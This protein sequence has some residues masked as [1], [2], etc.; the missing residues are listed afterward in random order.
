MGFTIGRRGPIHC[1]SSRSRTSRR[2]RSRASRSSRASGSTRPASIVCAAVRVALICPAPPGSRLGNRITA[3]RWQSM[4][5]ELGH[6][7]SIAGSGSGSAGRPDAVIALHARKS[8][9]AVRASR[10]LHPERPVVVALTGTDLY[11][12]IHHDRAAQE[13][14]ELADLLIVL[15]P[16]GAAELPARL[17]SKVRVVPQSAP[18]PRR[19]AAPSPRW[20]E[21]AVVGHLRREKDPLRAAMAARLLPASSRIRVIHAGRALTG[22]LRRAALAEQRQNPRY[23]WLGE[24]PRW[25]ARALIGR[26]RLLALTSEMEGGANVVSEAV[27]AGTPVL[28]SRIPSMEAIFGRAYPGLFPFGSTRALAALLS[29]AEGD[30]AFLAE[31]AARSRAL[32]PALSPSREKAALR[33][34]VAELRRKRSRG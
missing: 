20:F 11:R 30:P 29:R 16:A 22:G 7:A 24:L 17:R 34:V 32:R 14:L 5:R 13:S 25:Q 23:R 31:L 1:A 12:D 4:L 3:L 27:A 9:G 19:K 28:A 26:A 2:V 21:V 8:A 15:H 6:E 33:G 10:Q 18:P